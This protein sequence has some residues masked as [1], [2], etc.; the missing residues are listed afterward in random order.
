MMMRKDNEK[1]QDEAAKQHV[2]LLSSSQQK[3]SMQVKWRITDIA[4]R[5]READVDMKSYESPRFDVFFRGSH[6]LYIIAKIQGDKLELYL[7]KD[8]ELS[9]DKSRLDI[10]GT[11]ITVS[12]AGLPDVKK[13][14]ILKGFLSH[15][16]GVGDI[17]H[18]SRIFQ[19]ILK[20]TVS[21]SQSTSSTRKNQSCYDCT[22]I[23][24]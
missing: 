5:L 20:M 18:F 21:T 6:K 11:S 16:T 2:R 9:D 15:L 24:P 4:A 13:P 8:V 23:N 22:C 12:K 3:N 7:H 1:H 19:L 17:D 14:W 10:S